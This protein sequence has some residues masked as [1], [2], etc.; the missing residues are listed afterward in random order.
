VVVDISE[1]DVRYLD[2][3]PVQI[4]LIIRGQLPDQCQYEFYSVENRQENV[5]KITLKGIHPADSCEQSSQE[6]VHILL[7]GRDMAEANRG[8]KPGDYILIV[9]GYQ[10]G[11]SIEE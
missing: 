6:I 2:T 1:V 9:N 7:L 5:I 3:N 10:I 4:E 8:F 11:F